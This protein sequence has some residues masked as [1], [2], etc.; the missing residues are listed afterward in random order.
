MRLDGRGERRAPRSGHKPSERPR[1][2]DYL[3]PAAA[4]QRKRAGAGTLMAIDPRRASWKKGLLHGGP[5]AQKWA[6]RKAGR[7]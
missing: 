5:K 3:D 4:P 1:G 2:A 6:E 7:C